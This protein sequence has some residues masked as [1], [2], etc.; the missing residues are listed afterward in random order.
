MAKFS[1]IKMIKEYDAE[2][3]PKGSISFGSNFINIKRFVFFI[4]CLA[5]LILFLP[6]A[7]AGIFASSETPMENPLE[8]SP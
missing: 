4:S 2:F 1:E 6:F 8:E 7:K 3:R 5:V